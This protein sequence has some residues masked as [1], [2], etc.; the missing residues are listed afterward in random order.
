MMNGTL[1]SGRHLLNLGTNNLSKSNAFKPPSLLHAVNNSPTLNSMCNSNEPQLLRQNWKQFENANTP[2]ILDT[3]T[4]SAIG[5][6]S[7]ASINLVKS[8]GEAT[9]ATGSA[10]GIAHSTLDE[11]AKKKCTVS[12]IKIALTANVN[13]AERSASTVH[14]VVPERVARLAIGKSGGEA[15]GASGSAVGIAHLEAVEPTHLVGQTSTEGSV[16]ANGASGFAVGSGS[17]SKTV[18]LPPRLQEEPRTEELIDGQSYENYSPIEI[19]VI[20]SDQEE[21]PKY[22]VEIALKAVRDFMGAENEKLLIN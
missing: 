6:C 13:P 1:F 8:G 10:V 7:L 11:D 4:P 20:E 18:L 3:S 14:P 2:R 12:G 17:L 19:D 16:E 9:G 5:N 15:T 22:E 21:E